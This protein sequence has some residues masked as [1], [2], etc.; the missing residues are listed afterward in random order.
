MA[1]Y[2]PTSHNLLIPMLMARVENST[3]PCDI[4]LP[5]HKLAAL[6]PSID[7]SC[8]D[9]NYRDKSS[10]GSPYAFTWTANLARG[11]SCLESLSK[12]PE[13][14]IAVVSHSGFL[15]TAITRRKFANAD[16]RIFTFGSGVAGWRELFEDLETERKGGGMG[17][18]Q[19]GVWKVRE[20]D[21]PLESIGEE[22]D[23]EGSEG[24]WF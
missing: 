4:G 23:E 7:L 24:C 2:I 5:L 18:S 22:G 13:K 6:F 14:V 3:E 10:P 20:E 8:V 11:Q 16:Y 17:R 21:F 19:R 12:R 15:R 1:G 9:P